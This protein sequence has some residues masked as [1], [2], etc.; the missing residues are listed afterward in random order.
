MAPAC[1]IHHSF[2]INFESVQMCNLVLSQHNMSLF[3]LKYCIF[4][5]EEQLGKCLAFYT[6]WVLVPLLGCDHPNHIL[7]NISHPRPMC[8]HLAILSIMHCLYS[9]SCNC[10]ELSQWAILNY[11]T[12]WLPHS[13]TPEKINDFL[14]GAIQ[15][16]LITSHG[17]VHFVLHIISFREVKSTLILNEGGS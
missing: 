3:N 9:T 5:I 16:V 15:P 13:R 8:M 14:N 2:K 1:I 11:K 6:I 17:Y 4:Y 12:C 10:R 7:I